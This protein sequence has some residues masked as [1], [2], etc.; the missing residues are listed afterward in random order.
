MLK[1]VKSD[2]NN[3]V[4][5]TPTC[6]EQHCRYA[7]SCPLRQTLYENPTAE[8]T[9]STFFFGSRGKVIAK[10]EKSSCEEDVQPLRRF[11]RAALRRITKKKRT[12]QFGRHRHPPPPPPPTIP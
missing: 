8:I 5:I 6:Q 1:V 4:P 7:A 12:P 3:V 9:S 11:L 2:D 10:G